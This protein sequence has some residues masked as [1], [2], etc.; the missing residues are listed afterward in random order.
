MELLFQSKVYFVAP[1]VGIFKIEND[2]I[3]LFSNDGTMREETAFVM[4]RCF[5]QVE[6]ARFN[7]YLENWRNIFRSN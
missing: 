5:I 2:K 7:E 4:P 6:E 3:I 1:F